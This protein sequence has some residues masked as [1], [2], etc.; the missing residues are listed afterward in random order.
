MPIC[1]PCC[2]QNH[3]D[4]RSPRSCP[5]AHKTGWRVV[6]GRLVPVQTREE[7]VREAFEKT[8]EQHKEA[9]DRLADL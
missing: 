3:T 6:D 7:V 1:R 5:C 8:L 4:C 9:L 2:A